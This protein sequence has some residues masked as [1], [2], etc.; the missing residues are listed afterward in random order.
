MYC[1]G[2]S[3]LSNNVLKLL[4]KNFNVVLGGKYNDKRK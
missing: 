1:N 4:T 3:S 2:D